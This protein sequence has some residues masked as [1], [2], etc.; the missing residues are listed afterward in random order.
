MSFKRKLQW[1]LFGCILIGFG[2]R[3]CYMLPEEV[4]SS[5]VIVTARSLK[6]QQ[7]NHLLNKGNYE[8]NL[9]HLSIPRGPISLYTFGFNRRCAEFWSTTDVT[10]DTL[11]S[12]IFLGPISEWLWSTRSNINNFFNDPARSACPHPRIGY[13][14]YAVGNLDL[15][16]ELDIWMIDQE[17]KAY[18]LKDDRKQ[19]FGW[20]LFD[21]SELTN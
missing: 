15:D 8:V 9:K 5:S 6:H 11:D 18:H 17:G 7:A 10:S 2:V 1:T 21:D 19:L 14:M 16:P 13:N 4:L 3:G 20:T 12:G